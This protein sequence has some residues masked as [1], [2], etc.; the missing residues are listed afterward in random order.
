[1]A[2]FGAGAIRTTLGD[3]QL[4]FWIAGLLCVVAGLSFLTIGRRSFVPAGWTSDAPGSLS[5]TY[6][7]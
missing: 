7:T 1:M 5:A 3:Y 2:A 4:A 6:S